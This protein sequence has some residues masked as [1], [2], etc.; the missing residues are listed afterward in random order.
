M[1]E[2]VLVVG[3][4]GREHAIVT[5]L[6]RSDAEVYAVMK[7]KNPGIVRAAKD[8]ALIKETDVEK[9]VSYARSKGIELAIIGPEAPL[10]AGLTD[11]L[12]KDGVGC[13]GPSRSA[14]RLETSKSYARELME[15]NNI[16]GNLRFRT[17]VEAAPAKKYID[18][19]DHEVAVKPVGLTGGKGVKVQGEHLLTKSDVKAYIDEVFEKR[20]GGA[21]VVL[22]EKAIG[23]EFTMQAFCDGKTLVPMP[24]VQDHKRAY[25]GD[26]G[27]NTGGMGSYT[28]ADHL[29]P[30]VKRYERDE[31]ESILQKVVSAMS[32]E[33]SPYQGIIYGQF[34]LTKD[35]PKVIEF[36]ARFGDPEA[37]NVLTILSSNFTDVAWS[38]A[39]GYLNANKVSFL[40]KATVCKYVVPQGYGTT[41]R[42]GLP[43]KVNESAIHELGAEAYFAAVDEIDGKILTG[44]SRSVGVVGVADTIDGAER[45]CES[46]LRYVEGEA[47]YVRHDI[48]TKELVEKRVSHMNL[49]RGGAR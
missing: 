42:S 30:F 27:P 23:E 40:N 47:L 3:G 4:G 35:G 46:A 24:L 48:G 22:E 25:E 10:E 26:V 2:K 43:I 20:I 6:V 36:N 41:P 37:M 13:V 11:A 32:K 44:T 38:I 16:P 17:F 19:I 49:I 12:R 29:L 1:K 39:D 5:A 31:A 18:E 34:M 9:V 45:I 7:N 15:R 28:D 33:G 14:A 21:G 8:H